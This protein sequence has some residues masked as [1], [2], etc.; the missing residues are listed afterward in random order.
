M[1][2]I[3]MTG[4]EPVSTLLSLRL[5]TVSLDIF[6]QVFFRYSRQTKVQRFCEKESAI[7]WRVGGRCTFHNQRPRR[8]V[9]FLRPNC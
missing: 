6:V 9:A 7:S 3:Q 8:H 4:L 5:P 1:H 2:Y